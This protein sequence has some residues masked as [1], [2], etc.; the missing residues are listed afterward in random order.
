MIPSLLAAHALSGCNTTARYYGIA[1][2]TVV[3]QLKK[4][5]QLLQLGCTGSE[6]KDTLQECAEFISSC[7]DSPTTNMTDCQI[8]T[9]Q[10]KIAKDRKTVAQL[11]SSLPTSES[12]ELYVKKLH[13]QCAVWYATMDTRSPKLGP[14]Y[15]C[16]E[17]NKKLKTMPIGVPKD[18]KRAPDNVLK[19]IKCSCTNYHVALCVHVV[20]IVGNAAMTRPRL[21]RKGKMMMTTQLI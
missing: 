2:G 14:S 4:S 10:V 17:K 15:F 8:K 7:Y 13:F 21:T 16:W 20:E 5:L 18:W 1:K 11:K 6:S 3:K 9:W 19:T 12:F